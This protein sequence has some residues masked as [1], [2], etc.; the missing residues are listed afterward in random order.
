MVLI[1]K[2]P[3]RRQEET[4]DSKDREEIHRIITELRH[5][6]LQRHTE[7]LAEYHKAERESNRKLHEVERLEKHLQRIEVFCKENN[8]PLTSTIQAGEKE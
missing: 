1:T 6:Y 2:A 8:I 3:P 5:D 4:L 7:A